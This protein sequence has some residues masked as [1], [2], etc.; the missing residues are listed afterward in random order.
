MSIGENIRNLR[1]SMNMTQDEFAHEIGI[2]R[3]YLGDLE[4][5]R[6]NPSSE[7]LKRI[8]KKLGV[9]LLYLLQGK[10]TFTDQ[11]LLEKDGS[12]T[13]FQI[14][15]NES[16]NRL[17]ELFEKVNISK[18]TDTQIVTLSFFFEYLMSISAN[19]ESEKFEQLDR[20]LYSLIIELG[21]LASDDKRLEYKRS[22]E[23][24]LSDIA[25]SCAGIV[26]ESKTIVDSKISDKSNHLEQD[27]NPN[28]EGE[29]Y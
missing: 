18:F 11:L 5:N 27:F 13:P 1:K 10:V 14:L 7:T 9:S 16:H 23:S 8:S 3:S 28:K 24:L 4:N 19:N 6:R 12:S 26:K 25:S 2:S 21:R 17:L 22:F 29:K 20:Q 15:A